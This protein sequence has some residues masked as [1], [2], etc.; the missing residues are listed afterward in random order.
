VVAQ[1]LRFHRRGNCQG[2][3][4]NY[5]AAGTFLLFVVFSLAVT[6]WAARRTRSAAQF[7]T[8]GG[9]LSAW[10]NA[11]AIAGD[12]I[13]ASTFLG[14]TGLA[15]LGGYD[16][17][18][19]ILA[20]MAGQALLLI[21]IAEPFRNMGRYTF[22]DMAAYRLDPGP[23]RIIAALSS[24]TVILL[25]LVAQMVA[26]GALIQLLFQLDYLPA[27]VVIGT[28]MVVY[29]AGG[30]MLATTWVQIIKA[31]LMIFGVCVL[32]AGTLAH[33]DFSLEQLY[34]SAAAVHPLGLK[35]LAPGG[36]LGDPVST[37]SLA[38]ALVFGTVGMPHILMRLFTV[39]D[40]TTAYRSV[41]FASVLMG[42]VFVLV[43][44]VIGFGAIPILHAH[45]ELFDANGALMG[46]SNMVIIHL[47]GAVA[48]NVFL[49]F[50]S[51]VVFAT[52]LAVVAGLTLSG[53]TT[54]S[55]DIY[56]S[57]IKRG[58]VVEEDEL[59]VSR[60]TAVTLG[61]VAIL[62]A[63]VFE[64]QNIAY[65]ISMVFAVTASANCP[66]LF[67]AI[68]WRGL[69]TRGAVAGGATGLLLAVLLVIIGP[70]VWVE[71][72]GNAEPVF[73]YRYPGIISVPAGFL[74]TWLVS[75]CDRSARSEQDRLRYDAGYRQMHL[76][77]TAP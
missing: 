24:L 62:L 14:F 30:G 11:L 23:I 22:P 27:V 8:A 9:H 64:G 45:P 25:Y 60:I 38:L 76:G 42:L 21:L 71:L 53:A 49:G 46:G 37:I 32:A 18:I 19:Y 16:V 68:Y 67:L 70:T 3:S 35:V 55:H 13:S 4:L 50:I 47:A 36:L 52:I 44:F 28:L 65:L 48:G 54:W 2:K 61:V 40:A 41:F 57:V 1:S 12:F 10:Q 20:A 33:F 29:V 15:F 75:V 56:A 51:G 72:L 59:Y 74:V 34:R 39:P 7:Y 69:T 17:S 26:A 63:L 77:A 6:A 31:V 66:I 5:T 58:H 73:P 43:F